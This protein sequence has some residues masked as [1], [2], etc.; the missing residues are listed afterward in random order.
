MVSMR[1]GDMDLQKGAKAV[2]TQRKH[3]VRAKG[4]VPTLP[5]VRILDFYPLEKKSVLRFKLASLWQFSIQT[6]RNKYGVSL[7]SQALSGVIIIVCG[8]LNFLYFEKKISGKE[9]EED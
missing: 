5:D 2:H 8:M 1:R 3:H 4:K 9:E 7:G 6:G